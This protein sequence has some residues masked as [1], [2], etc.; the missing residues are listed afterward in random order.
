[1]IANTDLRS[2]QR[3]W[4]LGVAALLAGALL[5]SACAP[6]AAPT[7]ASTATLVAAAPVTGAPDPTQPV[8]AM[9]TGTAADPDSNAAPATPAPDT[10]AGVAAIQRLFGNPAL[11]PVLQGVAA[12]IN[13]PNGDRP[14]AYFDDD[15]LRYWVDLATGQVVEVDPKGQ[16]PDWTSPALPEAEL[17]ARA[18]QFILRATPDF[19]RRQ[20]DLAYQAGSKDG[21]LYFYRWEDH[22]AKGWISQPPLAQVGVTVSGRVVSYLNTLFL[23]GS[24]SP[25]GSAS[26]LVPPAPIT[27][28]AAVPLGS[29]TASELVNLRAGPS[30]EYEIVGQLAAGQRYRVVGQ[31]G[32]WWAITLNDTQTAWVFKD[33]VVFTS[34][35]APPAAIATRT[36]DAAGP[37][38][39]AVVRM[40][41]TTSTASYMLLSLDCLTQSSGCAHAPSRSIPMP[42]TTVLASAAWS[43]AG[44]QFAFQAGVDGAFDIYRVNADGTGLLKLTQSSAVRNS[45]SWSPDGRYLLY[46]QTEPN[47]RGDGFWLLRPDGSGARRIAEGGDAAWSPDGRQ[48]VFTV[49]A[50]DPGV[51]TGVRSDLYRL[52]ITAPGA[53]PAR[54]TDT[55][56]LKNAPRFAPDGRR[57]AFTAQDLG[58][59]G[60]YVINLD[61]AGLPLTRLDAPSVARLTPSQ[62]DATDPVWSPQGDSLAYVG[63]ASPVSLPEIYV[64]DTGGVSNVDVSNTAKWTDLD[65]TWSPDGQRLAF[66]SQNGGPFNVWLVNRDGS[67]LV[68]L[69]AGAVLVDYQAP[70]WQP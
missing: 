38:T 50:S 14:A 49:Q 70:S 29:I 8:S 31:A 5:L 28:S 35:A 34:E 53:L 68:A 57:L 30:T 12:L 1:M 6:G 37:N 46:T 17:R 61:G 59:W 64:V 19:P 45:L 24:L 15:Q 42:P 11:H 43:P 7:I 33:L 60:I 44:D 23:A 26:P 56:Q 69:T 16:Q 54:L 47:G 36:A 13:S 10:A 65:P 48:I 55:P 20:A 25:A 32:Q 21:V 3:G 18:E 66:T 51:S 63:N 58:H 27:P 41:G 40:D 39:L 62:W 9:A 2:R 52:D 67:G 22:Q 4:S